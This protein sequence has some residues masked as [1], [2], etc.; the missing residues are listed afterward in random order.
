M[1]DQTQEARLNNALKS[2]ENTLVLNAEKDFNE[3]F[4]N[5]NGS[6]AKPNQ[7]Y[8]PRDLDGQISN[9]KVSKI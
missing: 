1:A 3:T 7:K 5:I 6:K 9:Y 4:Q 8:D 2:V